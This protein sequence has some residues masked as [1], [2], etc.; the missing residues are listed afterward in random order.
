MWKN[1]ISEYIGKN[2]KC[3]I[4][5][6]WCNNTYRSWICWRRCWK[7]SFKINTGS[8]W[9]YRKSRKRN[10]LYRWNRQNNKEIGKS[11]NNKRCKWRRCSTSFIE[12]SRRN[13]CISSTTRRKKTS[14]TRII[15]NRYIKYTIYMWWCIWRSWKY[16]KRQNGQKIN[17]IWCWN[18]KQKRYWQI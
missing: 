12:N 10:N 18:S 13:N 7:Y 8:W 6:S 1:A 4:C 16:H 3:T 14:T 17:G 9:R 15:T 5:H 2:P 11:F